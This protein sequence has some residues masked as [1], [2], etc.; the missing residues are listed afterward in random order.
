MNLLFSCL[1]I[2]LPVILDCTIG[3]HF[4]ILPMRQWVTFTPP[5]HVLKLTKI[6]IIRQCLHTY[7]NFPNGFLET[8]HG[9]CLRREGVHIC[10]SMPIR[11]H[12]GGLTTPM[13]DLEA[14]SWFGWWL[15]RYFLFT[16]KIGGRFSPILTVAYFLQM[17]LVQPPTRFCLDGFYFIGMI[18]LYKDLG[19]GAQVRWDLFG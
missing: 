4:P 5:N 7:P 8:C 12:Q 15:L 1:L 9:D 14:E 3:S 16:L 17:G 2:L 13:A 19:N 18:F 11:L 10:Q 6:T